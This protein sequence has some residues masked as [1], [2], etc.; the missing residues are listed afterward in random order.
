MYV[1]TCEA[2]QNAL[3]SIVILV[4]VPER[5]DVSLHLLLLV[6]GGEDAEDRVGGFSHLEQLLDLKPTNKWIGEIGVP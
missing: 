5:G 6:V 1:T 3:S 4:L 2:N